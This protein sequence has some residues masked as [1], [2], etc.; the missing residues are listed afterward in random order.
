MQ[1]AAET[2]DEINYW[3]AQCQ[4]SSWSIMTTRPSCRKRCNYMLPSLANTAARHCDRTRSNQP[5]TSS[6]QSAAVCLTWTI[7]RRRSMF[8]ICG[9]SKRK[10]AMK[11]KKSDKWRLFIIILRASKW[12]TLTS[13][14]GNPGCRRSSCRNSLELHWLAS[15]WPVRGCASVPH[16]RYLS[17]SRHFNE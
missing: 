7:N 15:A 12:G 14:V 16:L 9:T 6:A 10:R 8:V 11:D 2:Q 4:H 17:V 3:V 1:C 5:Q 13:V